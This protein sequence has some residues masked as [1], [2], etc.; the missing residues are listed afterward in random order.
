MTVAQTVVVVAM[1]LLGVCS[2]QAGSFTPTTEGKK[3]IEYGWDSQNPAYIR[4]HLSEME[5]GP[6]DGVVILTPKY[7]KP[8]E[9]RQSLGW[10]VFGKERFQPADYEYLLPDLR[11]IHSK[12]L[13]D[14]YLETVAQRAHVPN[15]EWSDDKGWE[16]IC[17]NAAVMAMLAREGHCLG[18]TFDPEEYGDTPF[19]TA[20]QL[21][22]V[23]EGRLTIEQC[24]HLALERAAVSSSA[25]STESFPIFS[26]SAI[27][28]LR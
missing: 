22:A 18:L 4:A 2:V 28:A 20:S 3:I 21:P 14:N 13:T 8:G 7:A 12:K 11:A 23:K 9:R 19:W 10:L 27:S 5:K 24:R 1:M 15:A 26:S 16:T 25:P 17:H 6:F